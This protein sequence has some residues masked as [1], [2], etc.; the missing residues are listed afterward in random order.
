MSSFH[1]DELENWKL[2]TDE[3]YRKSK[4]LIEIRKSLLYDDWAL[5][6]WLSFK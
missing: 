4:K 3:I 6:W 1:I 2:Q 5:H